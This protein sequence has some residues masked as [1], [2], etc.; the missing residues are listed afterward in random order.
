MV[1]SKEVLDRFFKEQEA[2][3]VDLNSFFE[4]ASPF[5]RVAVKNTAALFLEEPGPQQLATAFLTLFLLCYKQRNKPLKEWVESDFEE[6]VMAEEEKEILN[7]NTPWIEK[8]VAEAYLAFMLGVKASNLLAVA[9][10]MVYTCI[11]M[12]KEI[13]E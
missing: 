12:Q 1:I 5:V 4:E 7:A 2:N 8:E 9:F 13:T 6:V 3:L 11:Q 10:F